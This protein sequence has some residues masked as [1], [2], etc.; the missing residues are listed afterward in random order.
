MRYLI[1]LL[2]WLPWAAK[3]EDMKFDPQITLSCLEGGGWTECIGA[4]SSACMEQTPGGHSTIGMIA[5]I[6][7]ET[8][9]WDQELNTTY[10]QTLA[11]DRED[12]ASFEPMADM[13]P[14]PSMPEALRDVQRA[15]IALRDVTCQYEELRWWGGSGAR[16]AGAACQMQMTGEQALR[17]RSY[18]ADG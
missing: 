7:A 5:C 11:R 13:P 1:V 18:L 17:L 4:S 12:E 3:A 8:A 14:R 16:I 9:W 10:Q 15:W 6:A 2:L